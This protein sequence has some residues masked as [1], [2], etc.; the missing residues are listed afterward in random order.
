V[1]ET[2]VEG[3]ISKLRKKLRMRMGYDPIMA[4]RFEGYTYLG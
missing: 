1:S 3:H 2:V 4:K